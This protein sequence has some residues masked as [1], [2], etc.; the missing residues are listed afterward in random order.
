MFF[1]RY[2]G[3]SRDWEI[4]PQKCILYTVHG[5]REVKFFQAFISSLPET[6]RQYSDRLEPENREASDERRMERLFRHKVA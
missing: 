4:D 6:G 2:M 1:L 3:N 5:K